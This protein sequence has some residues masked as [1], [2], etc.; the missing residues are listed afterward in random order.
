[1]H[2]CDCL[3]KAENTKRQNSAR[4][5]LGYGSMAKTCVDRHENCIYCGHRA[6]TLPDR[7]LQFEADSNKLIGLWKKRRW[8]MREESL[9]TLE[10]LTIEEQARRN[11][12]R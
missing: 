9:K 3:K 7:E 4:A 6:F 8:L 5:D 2:F 1:M 12:A 11:N 10:R